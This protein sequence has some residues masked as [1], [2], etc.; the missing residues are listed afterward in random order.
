M[1]IEFALQFKNVKEKNL[2]DTDCHIYLPL[3]LGKKSVKEKK[4][5]TIKVQEIFHTC[6][7]KWK[8]IKYNKI[9]KKKIK[10]N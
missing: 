3:P 7:L 4:T 10:K 2:R 5:A 6:S 8:Y 9:K 1:K